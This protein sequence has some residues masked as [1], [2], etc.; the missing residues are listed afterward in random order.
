MK[1]PLAPF[2]WN[3]WIESLNLKQKARYS[4]PDV[5][6]ALYSIS[7]HL[8]RY[9]SS[10][11][12]DDEAASRET[13]AYRMQNAPTFFVVTWISEPS[14]SNSLASMDL[15]TPPHKTLIGYV[16]GTCSETERLEHENMFQHDPKGSTFQSPSFEASLPFFC[17]NT[18]DTH[19]FL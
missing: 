19:I 12:P 9:F 2:Q 16:V 3:F 15:P 17:S 6:I 1:S 14:D 10:G 11:F 7:L 8:T 4:F 18:N 13:M 5:P